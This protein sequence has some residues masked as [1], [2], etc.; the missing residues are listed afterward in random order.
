VAPSGS[1][2]ALYLSGVDA[3]G[4][5]LLG[6]LLNPDD[7]VNAAWLDDVVAVSQASV[8]TDPYLYWAAGAV[9]DRYH[10]LPKQATAWPTTIE[11][12]LE[13]CCASLHAMLAFTNPTVPPGNH[14]WST[15]SNPFQNR[16][17]IRITGDLR[18]EAGA[19]VV[20]HDLDF[21]LEFESAIV[22]EEGARFS[23]YNCTFSNACD[24]QYWKGFRVEGDRYDFTQEDVHQ[25]QL[26]L[27]A[28]TVQGAYTGVWCGRE[29][30]GW[31]AHPS[32]GGGAVRAYGCTFRNCRI[33]ARVEGYHRYDANGAELPNL[34]YFEDCLFETTVAWS[35]DD[36]PEAGI[37]LR[38]VTGIDIKECSFRNTA[39]QL[40]P[41][42][43]RGKGIAAF[44]AGFRCLGFSQHNDHYFQDLHAGV[45]ASVPDP[46][47][48]YTVDGMGFHGNAQGLV[49]LGSTDARITNNRFVLRGADAPDPITSIGIQLFQSERYTVERNSFTDQGT[50]V[51]S[52]GIWFSG[53]AYEDNQIYDNEFSGL[54]AGT[55]VQD[56]HRGNGPVPAIL[57]G[58]QLLCG[59]HTDNIVDQMVV[60]DGYIK[61][62]QGLPV[63]GSTTA[64]NRYLSPATCA[65]TGSTRFHV[66]FYAWSD[67]GLDVRYNYYGNASS[68]E[69]RPDCI[70]DANGDPISFI[71]DWFYEL[72]RVEAPNP[73]DKVLNCPNGVLDL[74]DGPGTGDRAA[75]AQL[76]EQKQ[77]EW[78]AALVQYIAS[79]D[80]G[81][82]PTIEGENPPI[83]LPSM[84]THALL[85]L[86]LGEPIQPS[87]LLRDALLEHS[88]L[89]D[90]VLLAAV[91]RDPAL[92]HW[93]LTQVLIQNSPLSRAVQQVLDRDEPL[94]AYFLALLDQYQDGVGMRQALEHE[95]ALRQQEKTRLQ[96][97]LLMAYAADSTVVDRR[98]SIA[99]I[100]Q[101]DSLGD[102][103][104]GHYLSLVHAGDYTAALALDGAMDARGYGYLT[105]WGKVHEGTA[106]AWSPLSTEDRDG[107]FT[108]AYDHEHAVGALAWASL[109][110]AG[111]LD[112]LPTPEVPAPFKNLWARKVPRASHADEGSVL[113][114]WP[115]PAS[116]RVAFTYPEG[117]EKGTLEVFD[118]Q[119][120]L[121]R[122]VQLNGRK[123]IVESSVSDLRT[124][125]YAVRLALD[126]IPIATTK[127]TVMR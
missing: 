76:Y 78:H 84:D 18:I 54:N 87:H 46:A 19:D 116:D 107:L 109:L 37:Y 67:Y 12:G 44:D 105:A 5:A 48:T 60:Q 25:G 90:T 112:S 49:D 66:G 27:F 23:C 55:V 108:L 9:F 15:A 122:S 8:C 72:F 29:V 45:V 36:V 14:T 16:A 117:L 113:G 71:G 10:L 111:A 24:N 58:L 3:E 83:T 33:G 65:T 88:P 26:R 115:N 1:G 118:A 41:I 40:F 32:Y 93:H 120:R 119:G 47:K 22:I 91:Q 6:C 4:N 106:G 35:T 56:R 70:E 102:G 80:K 30:D 59:D 34:S 82:G 7:P 28:S 110:Q 21:R 95:V 38:D 13:E 96:H 85:H 104:R 61:Y 123:G 97:L 39:P 62:D 79:I 126:G 127:L 75:L 57:P 31:I 73:F 20:A 17:V 74:I 124:G 77:G 125:L 2:S 103:L 89:S 11:L 53:P 114:V 101:A 99:A 68:P 51:P 69:M 81:G 43:Y 94:P 98:D 52:V 50:N 42:E 63:S 92:D 86:V 100:F 121:V 64:N